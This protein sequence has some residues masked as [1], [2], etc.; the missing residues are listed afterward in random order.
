MKRTN[1]KKNNNTE[2]T[3]TG[4]KRENESMTDRQTEKRK[5]RKKERKERKKRVRA[6]WPQ[7]RD[8]NGNK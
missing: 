4:T 1:E 7:G 3:G 8:K 5:I 2:R 6:V